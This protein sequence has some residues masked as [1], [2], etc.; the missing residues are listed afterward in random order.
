MTKSFKIARRP[1]QGIEET[2]GQHQQHETALQRAPAIPVSFTPQV[3]TLTTR[4]TI[5]VPQDYFY[6]VK[7]RALQRRMKEKELWAE[8]VREYFSNHPTL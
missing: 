1:G 6:K 7:E 3:A 4:K 8:I 5:E 2:K